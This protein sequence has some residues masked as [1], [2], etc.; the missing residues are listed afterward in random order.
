MLAQSIVGIVD[1]YLVNILSVYRL[2]T[3]RDVPYQRDQN[4]RKKHDRK[5]VAHAEKTRRSNGS[6]QVGT[7]RQSPPMA[8][9]G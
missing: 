1:R 9:F 4:E 7:P 6:L 2:R 3:D 5:V 8:L